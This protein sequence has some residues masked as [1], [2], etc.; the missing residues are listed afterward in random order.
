MREKI[1]DVNFTPSP[2]SKIFQELDVT[3]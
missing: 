2:S 3:L 1:A